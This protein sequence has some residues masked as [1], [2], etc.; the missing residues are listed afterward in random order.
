MSCG[1]FAEKHYRPLPGGG[2]PSWLTVIGH[3][4]DSLWS[5][6][7]FRCESILL[8]THWVMVVMDQFSRSIIGFGVHVGDVDGPGLCRMFN[9]AIVGKGS[10]KHLS[11]DNDPLFKFHRWK[12]NLRILEVDEIKTVAY[13]PVSH[14]FVERLIGSIRREYLNHTLFWNAVDLERK[15]AHYQIY[16]NEQR[17]HSGIVGSTPTEKGGAASATIANLT[18]YRWQKHCGEAFQLP[19]AA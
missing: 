19:I 18:D 17:T 9:G 5:L 10:P 4:K 6:D 2:G 1:V 11:T 12:A 7:L 3:V 13:V 8:Q 15:L 16:F 14:P